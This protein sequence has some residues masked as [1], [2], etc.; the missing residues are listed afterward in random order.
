MPSLQ[1]GQTVR[2]WLQ[3][4][5]VKYGN[6]EAVANEIYPRILM[7]TNK[8]KLVRWDAAYSQKSEA[9]PRAR[10]TVSA[11]RERNYD[12]VDVS[13]TQVGISEDITD[14]DLQDAG[15]ADVSTP[16]MSM[17]AEA[18]EQN[19]QD[20]DIRQENAVAESIVAGTFITAAGGTD[21]EGLWAPPGSTNTFVADMLTAINAHQTYGTG[22]MGLRLAT[23]YKTWTALKL[24]DDLRDFVKYTSSKSVTTEMV[25]NWFNIQKVV[26]AG[27]VKNTA[28]E[29]AT[30]TNQQIFE[31]SSGKGMGFIYAYPKAVKLN[32]L[33]VGAQPVHKMPNGQ[34]RQTDR[35]Y[36]RAAHAWTFES[37][38]DI[39][40]VVLTAKAGYLW[41]D[42]YAT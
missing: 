35:R 16:P 14:E 32:M 5:S 15:V 21:A 9:L 8:A 28:N 37:R 38:E 36:D 1:E 11:K 6:L 40:T 24:S 13:T 39:G 41:D 29:G 26:V 25:A 30:A 10:G 3:G 33:A 31:S 42:T 2:G 18:I 27:M 4:V 17:Q 12:S 19:A 34:A 23:D 22:S 20:L 7:P